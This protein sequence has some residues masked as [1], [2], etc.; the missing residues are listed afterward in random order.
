MTLKSHSEVPVIKKCYLYYNLQKKYEKSQAGRKKA[1]VENSQPQ[2]LLTTS[3]VKD[4]NKD[5]RHKMRILR[6]TIILPF[7]SF[8]YAYTGFVNEE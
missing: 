2:P 3:S 1:E 7:T 6:I 8:S 4:K 5:E